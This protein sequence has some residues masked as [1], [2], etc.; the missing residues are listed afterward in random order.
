[1]FKK[2]DLV[3]HVVWMAQLGIVVDPEVK[4]FERQHGTMIEVA[5]LTGDPVRQARHVKAVALEKV[6]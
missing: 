2:G 5:W 6:I 1:M 4:L 3:K